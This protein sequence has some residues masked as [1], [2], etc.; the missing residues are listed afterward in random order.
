MA[1]EHAAA[2][3]TE[4]ASVVSDHGRLI[5][6]GRQWSL[7]RMFST[8]DC[9][10]VDYCR[11]FAPNRFGDQ[12]CAAVESFCRRHGIWLEDGGDHYNSMTPYLHPGAITAERMTVIGI[13]NA[14]LFWLNDT[15][16]REKFGHLTP[17]RQQDARTMVTRLV[18]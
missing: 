3:E 16:G 13:Y 1:G 5:A 14:I 7:A 15:V 9:D 18:G 4:F 2:V 17:H 6:Q 12:A 11:D 10:I 8:Q